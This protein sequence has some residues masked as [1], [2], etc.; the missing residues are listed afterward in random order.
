MEMGKTYTV[1]ELNNLE[2]VNSFMSQNFV[3]LSLYREKSGE[4][5]TGEK[6]YIKFDLP[7]KPMY[8]VEATV[9]GFLIPEKEE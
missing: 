9:N 4:L 6:L 3:K 2:F 5:T 1:E 8:A 7:D